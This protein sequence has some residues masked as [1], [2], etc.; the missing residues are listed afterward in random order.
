MNVNTDSLKRLECRVMTSS[1]NGG[2]LTREDMPSVICADSV[3]QSVDSPI[4]KNKLSH[5]YIP[6]TII[7]EDK[8]S[9]IFGDVGGL[10]SP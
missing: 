7:P 2:Y 3:K 8:E 10:V 6:F 1:T 5:V 4:P 9:G